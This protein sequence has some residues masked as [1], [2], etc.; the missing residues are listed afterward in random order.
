MAHNRHPKLCVG[1]RNVFHNFTHHFYL[2]ISHMYL[3]TSQMSL[4]RF[5]PMLWSSFCFVFFQLHTGDLELTANRHFKINIF[6]NRIHVTLAP[7][8]PLYFLFY[9]PCDPL[10]LAPYTRHYQFLFILHSLHVPSISLPRPS[11]HPA[12]FLQSL[13]VTKTLFV[14]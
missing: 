13:P 11:R 7:V 14:V 1:N 9:I 2:M 8:F 3:Q 12:L 10:T 5:R 6:K 4:L